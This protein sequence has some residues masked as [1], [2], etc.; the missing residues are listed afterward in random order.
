MAFSWDQ[1]KKDAI[2]MKVRRAVTMAKVG[3]NTDFKLAHPDWVRD[4]Q[5][6]NY[7]DLKKKVTDSV[8]KRQELAMAR[9][10]KLV[11]KS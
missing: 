3:K 4:A 6:K 11:G 2:A 1:T 7:I 9:R 5:N 8:V 10:Q